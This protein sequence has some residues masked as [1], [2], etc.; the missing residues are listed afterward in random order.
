MNTKTGRVYA[1]VTSIITAD[2]NGPNRFDENSGWILPSTNIGT[3]VDEFVRDFFAGTLKVKKQDKKWARFAQG[4]YEVSTQGDK[5]FSALIATFKKGTIIEGVDVGGMTIERVYQQ[6]IKKSGKGK[7]PAQDSKLYNPALKT[8]QEQEDFSYTEGYLPLW[9]I[10]AEQ[11]PKL[12][13]ELSKLSEGKVLTDKFASTRVS[14]ARALA[15]ILNSTNSTYNYPNATPQQ[16]EAFKQKLE[17][18]KLQMKANGFHII[19][20]DVIAAGTLEVL[21][22]ENKVYNI[23]TAGTLDLL[24]YNDKGEF[25]VFDMKTVRNPDTI[26]EKKHKWSQ[27]TSLYQKFLENTYGIKIKGR[28]I[29]P[30][31]VSYPSPTRGKYTQGE[32]TAILTDGKPFEDAKPK[33]MHTVAVPFYEPHIVYNKLTEQEKELATSITEIAKDKESM[34]GTLVEAAVK[35]SETPFIDPTLGLPMN[36]NNLFNGYGNDPMLKG[37][38]DVPTGNMMPT[39]MA[40]DNLSEEKRNILEKRG[41]SKE[42]YSKIDTKEEIEHIKE[43]LGL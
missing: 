6:I 37:T 26:E 9:K 19:P 20:R 36:N 40:W 14:Q 3:T 29:I 35:E 33:L 7:A 41:F 22:S 1:R 30:I 11:N 2:K 38:Q 28:H 10:W 39:E 15:D 23:D 24:A 4:R 25:F 21:D 13:V 5:R 27:Q 32:G 18:L 42:S 12:I 8:K 31:Q 17:N 34:Q 43:C 16:W